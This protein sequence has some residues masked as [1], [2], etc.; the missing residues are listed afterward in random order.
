MELEF[1][2]STWLKITLFLV[3][4]TLG[5]LITGMWL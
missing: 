1:S 5:V 4:T 3:G 2:Q